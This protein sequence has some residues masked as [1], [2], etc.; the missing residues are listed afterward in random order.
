MARTQALECPGSGGVITQ[1]Q[2]TLFEWGAPLANGAGR[3][4]SLVGPLILFSRTLSRVSRA[5][6]FE[7]FEIGQKFL[8]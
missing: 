2:S 4:N 3:S 1:R 8:R 6:N 7:G 5:L